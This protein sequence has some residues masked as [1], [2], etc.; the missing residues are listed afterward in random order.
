MEVKPNSLFQD[1]VTIKE[2]EENSTIEPCHQCGGE[3]RERCKSCGGNQIVID[4]LFGLFI[5]YLNNRS[6]SR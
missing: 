3:G 6:K 4:N 2:L 1:E 5:V